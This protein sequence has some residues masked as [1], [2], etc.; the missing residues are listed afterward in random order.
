M[1]KDLEIQIDQI[2]NA[3]KTEV[4][5][6]VQKAQKEAAKETAA[7]LRATSPRSKKGRKGQ[8]AKGWS[9]RKYGTG[10]VTY[11]RTD[12]QLTHLLENGHEHFSH[13]H[14]TGTR[15]KANPHIKNAEMQ[16]M[17]KYLSEIERELS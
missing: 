14:A 7:M 16:M 5:E 4:E 9:F 6:A 10:Y 11:N 8:Y 12:P 15:A 17:P 1:N 13:G 3:Y 2:L